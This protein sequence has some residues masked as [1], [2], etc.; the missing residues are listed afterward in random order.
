[1]VK[2]NEGGLECRLMQGGRFQCSQGVKHKFLILKISTAVVGGSP[3]T[4][5]VSSPYVLAHTLYMYIFR[6]SL[7][8]GCALEALVRSFE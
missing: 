7:T 3:G 1:M 8:V 5:I 6:S 2:E 4:C